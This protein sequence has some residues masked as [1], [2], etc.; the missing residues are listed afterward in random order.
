MTKRTEV[1]RAPHKQVVDPEVVRAIFARAI[2]AHVAIAVDGQPFALPVA[3]APYGE[4]LLLHGS[5]ASRLFR[6]LMAGTP[7]CVTITH[8]D[9]LVLA[10]SSF[11]SSM[12]YQSLMALGRARV[13]SEDEKRLALQALTDHLFPQRRAELRISTENEIKATA[14]VAFPLTEISVK[15]S[16]AQPN[17]SEL[18]L[19]SEVWAGILPLK[20]TYGIPIAAENLRPDI[21]VP[22]YITTWPPR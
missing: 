13:I 7:A 20:L 2:T 14:I 10:R 1:H 4:E 22:D 6:E 9:A 11:E 12:H 21:S 18:D 8:I 3:C 17:D 15:V 19:D 16:D 5:T